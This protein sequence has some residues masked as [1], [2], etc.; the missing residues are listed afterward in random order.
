MGQQSCEWKSG[1]NLMQ[2]R[3]HEET[4]RFRKQV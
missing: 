4:Y 2:D 1:L 3:L